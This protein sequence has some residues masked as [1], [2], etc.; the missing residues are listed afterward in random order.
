MNHLG[1]LRLFVAPQV[2]LALEGAAAQVAGEGFVPSVL[3][4]VRDE[5]AALR[6]CLT[7][8]DTLVR[9]FPCAHQ[10]FRFNI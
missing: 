1:V 6:E 5:V 2:N 10:K 7:A 3:P 4:R 8:H 9:L